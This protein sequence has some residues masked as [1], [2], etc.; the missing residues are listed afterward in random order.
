[1]RVVWACLIVAVISVVIAAASV[2]W[3]ILLR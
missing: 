2:G 3:V 1:M